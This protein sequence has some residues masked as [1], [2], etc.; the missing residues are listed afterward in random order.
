MYLMSYSAARFAVEF[1]RY[2]EQGNLS[3]EPLDT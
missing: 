1:F 2:H 3:G